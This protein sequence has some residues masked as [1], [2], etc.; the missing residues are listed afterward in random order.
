MIVP[1]RS[2][3]KACLGWLAQAFDPAKQIPKGLFEHAAHP[4]PFHQPHSLSIS[5]MPCNAQVVLLTA[6]CVCRQ[7]TIPAVL[8]PAR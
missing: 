3:A 7:A 2:G 8:K 6:S 4:C 1:T 5:A